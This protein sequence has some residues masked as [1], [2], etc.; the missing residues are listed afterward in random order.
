ME[1]TQKDKK[2]KRLES[3]FSYKGFNIFKVYLSVK[4]GAF[5]FYQLFQA[6]PGNTF[7]GFHLT[8]G[9]ASKKMKSSTI[10]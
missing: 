8:H 7:G 1:N 10:Q 5:V 2:D 9:H 4:Y 3:V 6:I